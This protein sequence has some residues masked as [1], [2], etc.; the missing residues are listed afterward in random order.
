MYFV[1]Y[2]GQFFWFNYI[3]LILCRNYWTL[4]QNSVR[5]FKAAWKNARIKT[6]RYIVVFL[7]S[8]EKLN[9]IRLCT[10]YLLWRRHDVTC[11]LYFGFTW[12]IMQWKDFHVT[13]VFRSCVI[14]TLARSLWRMWNF[15]KLT[16]CIAAGNLRPW[17]CSNLCRK[18]TKYCESFSMWVLTLKTKFNSLRKRR[19]WPE[20]WH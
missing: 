10:L 4:A 15:C 20:R 2:F 13:I 8:S 3:T 9:R 17:L 1:M 11:V 7:K 14:W 6:M 12:P 19:C 18:R 16:N 5:K